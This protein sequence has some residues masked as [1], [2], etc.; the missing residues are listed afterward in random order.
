MEKKNKVLIFVIV[1]LC[2][3]VLGLGGYIAFDKLA[4]NKQANNNTTTTTQE[5]TTTTATVDNEEKTKKI[6]LQDYCINNTDCKKDLGEIE[7]NNK[8]LKLSIDVTKF[9]VE[10]MKGYITL[11]SKKLD[12]SKIVDQYAKGSAI[13]G[14]EVYKDYLIIYRWG[15]KAEDML[16]TDASSCEMWPYKMFIYNS[17]LEEVSALQGYSETSGLSSFE[18]KDGYLYY[19]ELTLVDKEDYRS[20]TMTYEKIKFSDL[21]KKDYD[22]FEL[23]SYSSECYDMD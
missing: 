3:L 23:I 2:V 8:K 6:D 17:D 18:I 13:E 15:S 11:G 14:F 4:G 12:V 19:Y 5:G 10:G 22:K 9:N 20:P 1:I 16:T 7:I 21:V